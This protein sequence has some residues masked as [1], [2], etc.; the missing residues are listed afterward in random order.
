MNAAFYYYTVSS[1]GFPVLYLNKTAKLSATI[2]NS[3]LISLLESVWL[4]SHLSYIYENEAELICELEAL[5]LSL[6]G[7][8]ANF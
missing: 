3:S 2:L 7:I 6:N 4:D 5:A 1:T 8:Y